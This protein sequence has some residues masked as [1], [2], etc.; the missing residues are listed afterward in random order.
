MTAHPPATV[1]PA[2]SVP[3]TPIAAGRG[4]ALQVLVGPQQG[5]TDFVLRRFR[6]DA[7]GGMPL[8]TNLVEHQQYVLR[9]RARLRIA[10]AW[11]EVGADDTTFIPAGVP[12]AYEVMEG[13]FEFLCVVPDRPDEV[14]LVAEG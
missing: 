11:H 3:F 8:H 4:T 5:E 6:M 14:R 1:R 9:G 10:D 12:H 7:G 2:E 13:P